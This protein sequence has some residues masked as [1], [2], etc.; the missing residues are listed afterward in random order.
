MNIYI[1]L[2]TIL[3]F[4]IAP[5]FSLCT[6]AQNSSS[7]PES[8]DGS[9]EN[10]FLIS[11]VEELIW[12]EE[13]VNENST[14]HTSACAKLI[15]NID[16]S[17]ISWTPI[18]NLE[19][20][21]SYNGTFDGNGK[22][23]SNLTCIRNANYAGLFGEV[24]GG[25]IKNI[26]FD[27]AHIKNTKDGTGI[28]AARAI[29]STI[30][31]IRI[32]NGTVEGKQY[33]GSITGV[34]ISS[35]IINC[36]IESNVSGNGIVGGIVGSF[37]MQSGKANIL[38]NIFSSCNVECYSSVGGI[39]TAKIVQNAEVRTSGLVAYNNDAKLI[40]NN[41]ELQGNEKISIGYGKLTNGFILGCSKETLKSGVVTYMLQEKNSAEDVVWGQ[42]LSTENG[43]QYPRLRSTSRVYA[44][45]DVTL[46]CEG[47]LKYNGTFTNEIIEDKEMRIIH[48]N[49]KYTAETPATCTESGIRAH[50]ECQTC[51]SAFEDEQLTIEIDDITE[52]LKSHQYGTNDVCTICSKAI[53]S[54]NV[55][56]NDIAIEK[57]TGTDNQ[58]T[59]YNLFKFTPTKTGIFECEI[60]NLVTVTSLWNS[61]KTERLFCNT[62]L[63]WTP[64]KVEENTTYY[65]GV[66]MNKGDA[67]NAKLSINITP[68]P[69]DLA[70]IGN[71]RN[72]FILNS[73]NHLKFFA[74]F[75][76]GSSAVTS[77]HHPE[78]CAKIA[79]DVIEI[80]MSSICHPAEG[81]YDSEVC[82]SPIT[83]SNYWYGSFDGNGKTISNL[84]INANTS[85]VGMF[86]YAN[87]GSI[88]KN[89][90]LKKAIVKNAE[91][92]D[93]SG[94][95]VGKTY[96]LYG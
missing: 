1:R 68:C 3:L 20:N 89:L 39:L 47:V 88:I 84:Y 71:A 21:R 63:S 87:E 74:D 57:T 14:D 27:K 76:N 5:N 78:A 30:S 33:I 4:F 94:I 19:E 58:V 54:V 34:S 55:G 62:M 24:Q 65:I 52:P 45:C 96:D 72:P 86:G 75:V 29:K 15:E 43:D 25:I 66:K 77:K 79:D 41:K 67:Y 17:N 85:N 83:G 44:D 10:P 13:W 56:D 48:S 23:I 61:E 37:N 81:S 53:P 9:E 50:Y 90:T 12:F 26:I 11:S 93:N 18:A 60:S 38:K 95:L 28:V 32:I 8:G 46:T 35:E 49:S 22:T 92:Q 64:F 6:L 42:N 7:R 70:G 2:F 69:D 73:A 82:W 59:S 16:L 40:I 80:D 31:G 51:H 36:D 91:S